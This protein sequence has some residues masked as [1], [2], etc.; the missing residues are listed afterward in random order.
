MFDEILIQVLRC[1]WTKN[2]IKNLVFYFPLPKIAKSC[3]STIQ[4]GEQ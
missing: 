1:M 3:Y 2:K 4:C